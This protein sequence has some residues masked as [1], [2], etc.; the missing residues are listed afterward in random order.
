MF[1]L[2]HS[3]LIFISGVVWLAVG[4]GLLTLGLKLLTAAAQG[5][6]GYYPL[7]GAL[8]SY[9]GGMAQTALFFI[10]IGLSLGYS[11]SKYV[12]SKSVK[13]S[14]T[15]IQSFPNPTQLS[16]IYSR[17]YYLLLGGMIGLGL[18]IKFLGIP[19]DIRGLID[20]AVGA[21][22]LNGSMLYFRLGWKMKS[23]AA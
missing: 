8:S 7:L 23:I 14:V 17:G 19:N 2:T 12:L 16:N 9:M 5:E 15:R 6:E 4:T 11:K 10:V 18:S 3:T 13:R 20:T 21:A 1:K 22:L